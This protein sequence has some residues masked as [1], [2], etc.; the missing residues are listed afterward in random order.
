MPSHE[1]RREIDLSLSIERVKQGGAYF[2]SLSR[3]VIELLAIVSRDAGGRHIE[4]AGE[5]ER[6]GS[7]QDATHGRD[8]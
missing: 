5:I 7:M 4:I 1:P 3:Q 6:H 2:S 8:L